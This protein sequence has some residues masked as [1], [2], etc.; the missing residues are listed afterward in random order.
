MLKELWPGLRLTVA[1]TIVT[2]FLYP[3]LM[4]GLSQAIFPYQANGSLVR[5]NGKI[6]G[7]SLIGQSFTQPQYFHPRPSDA[8]AGYDPTQSGGSNLGLTNAK[9]IAQIKSSIAEFRK[10]NPTFT[11]PVP[12]DIVTASAS[13]LDPDISPA[14]AEDQAERVAAARGLSVSAV[15]ELIAHFRKGPEWGFLGA[16]RVNVL[17]LNLALDR[18]FPINRTPSAGNVTGRPATP[19][20]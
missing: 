4:T 19:A 16:S 14:A 7:S 6:A 3:L 13:G 2:G 12:A 1:F 17:M 20:R 10:E 5:V 8:G 11:G 15:K 9:L 18:R